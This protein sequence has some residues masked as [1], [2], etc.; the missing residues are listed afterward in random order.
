MTVRSLALAGAFVVAASFGAHAAT[1]KYHATL[2]A[3]SEVPPT[4]STGTGEATATL[5]TATHELTVDVTFSGFASDVTAAHI[6]GP[7]PA[8]KNAGVVVPLGNAPKS[9]IHVT[10]KLTEAQQKELESGML[11]VNVHTKNDPSGAIRGQLTK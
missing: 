4:K 7:A 3:A 5:D 9:P 1:V 8:G 10:A 6:H 11:Y 2:T